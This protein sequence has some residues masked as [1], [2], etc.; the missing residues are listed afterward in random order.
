MTMNY[1][2]EVVR[3][4]IFFHTVVK[5]EQEKLKIII[6]RHHLEHYKKCISVR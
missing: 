2:N 1:L 5:F 4:L 3:K 6:L